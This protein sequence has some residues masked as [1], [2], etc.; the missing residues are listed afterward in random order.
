MFKALYAISF[1]LL[2]MC[3]YVELTLKID[4]VNIEQLL[5][6]HLVVKNVRF[7]GRN[8]IVAVPLN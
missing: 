2:C 5:T 8:Q 7:N 3:T 4:I 1:A 6:S